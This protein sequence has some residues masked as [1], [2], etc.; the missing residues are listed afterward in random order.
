[1]TK[2]DNE[3]ATTTTLNE[4]L[5]D[6]FS[7]KLEITINKVLA[8]NSDVDPRPELLVTLCGFSAQVSIDSGY[9][10]EE[11]LALMGE[12][13]DDFEPEEEKLQPPKPKSKVDISKMN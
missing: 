9:S 5:L 12:I 4:K 13:F 6:E 10:K 11:L 8:K 7:D 1:M 3:A 2:Q